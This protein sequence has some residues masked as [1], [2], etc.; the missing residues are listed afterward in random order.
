M[1]S[2]A[3]LKV[4]YLGVNLVWQ[5]LCVCVCAIFTGWRCVPTTCFTAAHQR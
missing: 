5:C 1:F 4:I 3:S 2:R